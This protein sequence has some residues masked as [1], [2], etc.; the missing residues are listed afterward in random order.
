[1]SVT[2][3]KTVLCAL[4]LHGKCYRTDCRFSH[5]PVTIVPTVVPSHFKKAHC[6]KELNGYCPYKFRCNFIHKG[7]YIEKHGNIMI[8]MKPHPLIPFL[9]I[10]YRIG[11][12]E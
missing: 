1:M 2:N 11:I 9:R 3:E 10:I 7:D 8:V 12:I 6:Q 4:W 5:D